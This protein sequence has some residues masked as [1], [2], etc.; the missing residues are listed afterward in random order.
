MSIELLGQNVEVTWTSI[1]S[2]GSSN[3]PTVVASCYKNWDKLWATKLGKTWT[4]SHFM[5]QKPG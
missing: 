2:R 1:P 3:T 4:S 5:L